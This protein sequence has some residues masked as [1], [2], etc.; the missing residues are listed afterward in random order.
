MSISKSSCG[1]AIIDESRVLVSRDSSFQFEIEAVCRAQ[2]NIPERCKQFCN[3]WPIGSSCRYPAPPN[4]RS[5]VD[6][7]WG[8]CI[9]VY[10]HQQ[11]QLLVR[12]Y[13][14]S[15]RRVAIGS[16]RATWRGH[17][18]DLLLTWAGAPRS[19]SSETRDPN[20]LL[21]AMCSGVLLSLSP[22]P[23]SEPFLKFEIMFEVITMVAKIAKTNRQHRHGALGLRMKR[24]FRWHNGQ[25]L[26]F[27]PEYLVRDTQV[28]LPTLSLLYHIFTVDFDATEMKKRCK[29][30]KYDSPRVCLIRLST[31]SLRAI[32]FHN[33]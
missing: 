27:T 15:A 17:L 14:G 7:A 1:A 10:S 21:A 16:S 33:I 12:V 5:R 11:P 20:P 19:N 25:S 22:L 31:L 9:G 24:R 18:P 30:Q 13:A 2:P 3:T 29:L 8:T 4:F 32:N 26:L 6:V 23:T 28:R